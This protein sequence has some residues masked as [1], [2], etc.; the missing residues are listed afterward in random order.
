MPAHWNIEQISR[1]QYAQSNSDVT[2]AICRIHK[3]GAGSG[4]NFKGSVPICLSLA[5]TTFSNT[6]FCNMESSKEHNVPLMR[7]GDNSNNSMYSGSELELDA[8]A[9]ERFDGQPCTPSN[10]RR[11]GIRTNL[12]I[13]LAIVSICQSLAI[14]YISSSGQ[15]E[16]PQSISE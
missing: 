4:L 1:I 10:G 6:P 11:S 8:N 3:G 5:L 16:C 7:R 2:W 13:F 12:I 14:V 15:K 9:N